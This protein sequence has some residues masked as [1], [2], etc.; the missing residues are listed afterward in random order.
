MAVCPACRRLLG[1]I[2]RTR[3]LKLV[4]LLVIIPV[5]A[6]FHAWK[7]WRIAVDNDVM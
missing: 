3:Y 1:V 7:N 4:A 6:R 5:V 2:L